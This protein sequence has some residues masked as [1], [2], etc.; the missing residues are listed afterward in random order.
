MKSSG[1]PN[2]RYKKVA[3]KLKK[4]H[5]DF[6]VELADIH[7]TIELLGEYVNNSTKTKKRGKNN[8]ITANELRTL[9]NQYEEEAKQKTRIK[10][11]KVLAEAESEMR[12]RAEVGCKD[13]DLS[14]SEVTVV[15][16]LKEIVAERGFT[17]SATGD[18]RVIRVS[19]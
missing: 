16:A 18:I 13:F 11:E 12:L 15:N 9:V 14:H 10:A 2:C 19:W 17:W 7:P 8:M 6:V 5:D 3:L 4:K 1:C